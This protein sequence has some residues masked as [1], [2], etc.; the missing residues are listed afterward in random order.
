MQ[1]AVFQFWIILA[2]FFLMI[3]LLLYPL[4]ALLVSES[5]V[6]YI[7][8]PIVSL[9]FFILISFFAS[10][11]WFR[12]VNVST[13]WEPVLDRLSE[14][15]CLI[16]TKRRIQFLN[17]G[18]AHF[19][20]SPR[21]SVLGKKFSE[22]NQPKCSA[23][24]EEAFLVKKP[25]MSVLKP[26]AEHNKAI[27]IVAFYS[28]EF[29]QVV[30]L[31]QDRTNVHRATELARDFI[32][33]ASHEL[34]TPITIIRGF[35]ETLHDHPELTR[36]VIRQIIGKIVV[37]C[38]RMEALVK[39]L[40]ALAAL[41]DGIQ[42]SRRQRCAVKEVAEQA[43]TT[44]I[45]FH[46]TAEITVEVPDDLSMDGDR[47][48]L[49]QAIMNLLDNAIKYSDAPAKIEVRGFEDD[50]KIA[51]EVQD[52]GHGIAKEKL[53]RI[54]ERFYAVDKSLSNRMG[55]YGLGLS[56]VQRVVEQHHGKITLASEEGQGTTFTL[57]FPQ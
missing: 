16:D 31:F 5:Q 38:R 11:F 43:R 15:V 21:D 44:I 22:T 9:L 27:D 55:G 19:I 20:G 14:G 26:T 49:V 33:N 56:I 4:S 2:I 42:D 29:G 48:L 18:C 52:H 57:H 34:K 1:K 46:P 47:S 6:L 39:N 25:V 35:S 28:K 23:L 13:K 53:D 36:E 17:K 51:I 12:R 8:V 37:N 45:S 40:L 7:L 41:D 50:G 30:L 54:F 32:T 10:F 3:T 24:I